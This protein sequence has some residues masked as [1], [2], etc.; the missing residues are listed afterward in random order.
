MEHLRREAPGGSEKRARHEGSYSDSRHRSKDYHDRAERRF[1]QGQSNRP[2][3]A[4][5]QSLDG[6]RSEASSSQGRKVFQSGSSGHGS[7]SSWIRPRQDW[8]E[9][10]EMGHWARDYCQH[11]RIAPV[12]HAATPALPAPPARGR[13]QGQDHK[14]G[15][16]AP[17]RAETEVSDD[18]ITGTI[19]LCQQASLPLFDPSSTFSYVSVYYAS[20]LSMMSEPL[21]APLRVS[22]PVGESLVVDQVFRSCLVTIQGRDTRD[23][24]ILLD[25]VDFDVIL[26]MDSLSPYHAV[27]DCFSKTVTLDILAIP[28]VS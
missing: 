5:L 7:R 18:V 24:L 4:S 3:Q 19:L 1:R 26:G 12:P 2:T 20:R 8:Y 13:G 6:G 27:L 25:M 23:D 10:G 9:C 17:A 28:P 22:N 15:Q 21:V 16:Q 11:C 14:V